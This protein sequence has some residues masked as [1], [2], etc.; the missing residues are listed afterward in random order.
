MY[1]IS[2]ATRSEPELFEL[3]FVARAEER[4]EEREQP[5]AGKLIFDATCAPADIK[6]PT[7]LDLLNQ[8]CQ[9]TEKILDC[10]YQ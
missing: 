9:S 6:Y 10:L 2:T 4:G 1:R 5:N 3:P 8:A 7:D